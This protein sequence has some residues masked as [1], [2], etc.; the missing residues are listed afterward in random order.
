MVRSSAH[1][2]DYLF[3][4]LIL[5]NTN[6]ICLQ[7]QLNEY[8]TCIITTRYIY[9]RCKCHRVCTQTSVFTYSQLNNIICFRSR[10]SPLFLVHCLSSVYVKARFFKY[11][12]LFLNCRQNPL[13]LRFF[14][15]ATL[16]HNMLHRLM[17]TLDSWQ[18]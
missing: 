4:R 13:F 16:L 10:S 3:R 18:T 1:R 5:Y 9:P 11:L 8:H 14:P 2:P 12:N 7:H 6:K 17:K 15:M